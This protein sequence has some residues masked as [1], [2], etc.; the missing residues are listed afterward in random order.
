MSHWVRDVAAAS[1]AAAVALAAT[2]AFGQEGAPLAA[3]GKRLFTE[4]GCNGCHTI[5]KIG[6]PIANDLTQVGLKYP[7]SYLRSWLRDPQ[8]QKPRAH[9]PKIEMPEADA[10]ALAAYLSSL[11]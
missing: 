4:Q 1:V 3:Q 5:G 6:T 9:M 10:R 2:I 8:E 11:R 7:E